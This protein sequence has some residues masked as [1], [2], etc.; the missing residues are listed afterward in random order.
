MNDPQYPRGKLDKEDEG[1]LAVVITQ[2]K[3]VVRIDFKKKVAW[4]AFPPDLAIEFAEVIIKH[5]K[6]IKKRAH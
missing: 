4:F 6:E 1:G 3:N 2:Y 5:A